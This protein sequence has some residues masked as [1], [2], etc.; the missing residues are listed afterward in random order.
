MICARFE[1]KW[2]LVRHH[3]RNSWEISGGHIEKSESPSEAA[4]REVMEETGAEEFSLDCVATYSVEKD[5]STGYGRLYFAEVTRLGDIPD[6]SEI[7]ETELMDCLPE[8]LTYP[9]IQPYL[10]SK[11]IEFL[12]TSGKL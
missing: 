1:G 2:I 3:M 4:Y 11:T 9:D 5:G 12:E 8:N 7:A 6:V 10:F